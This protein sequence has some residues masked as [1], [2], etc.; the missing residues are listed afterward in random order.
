MS[1]V[2]GTKTDAAQKVRSN[3]KKWSKPLMDAGWT[4]I[5]NVIIEKQRGFGLSA[6]DMT[7]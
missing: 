4:V 6:I 3:E 1:T 2:A 7:L 5:S